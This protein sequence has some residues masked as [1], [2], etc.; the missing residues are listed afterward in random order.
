MDNSQTLESLAEELATAISLDKDIYNNLQDLMSQAVFSE[1]IQKS[2]QEL[3]LKAQKFLT[4]NESLNNQIAV[5]QKEYN[6]MKKSG[7]PA[8]TYASLRLKLVQTVQLRYTAAF[9]FDQQLTKFYGEVP[10]KALYVYEN[11]KGDLSTYELDLVGLI[12]A[13][14]YTGKILEGKA[15]SEAYKIIETDLK[16]KDKENE[17]H[18][19]QAQSAYRGITNRLGRF[20]EKANLST[21]QGGIVMWK[22]GRRWT[23]AQVLNYGDLKEAYAAAIMTKHLSDLDVLCGISPGS[24][25]YYSHELI[26]TFFT[27]YVYNVTNKAAVIEEDIVTDIAQ[28]AVKGAKSALPGISQY[29]KAAETITGNTN[30]MN[31]EEFKNALIAEFPEEVHRNKTYTSVKDLSVQE[32][33]ETQLQS[34]IKSSKYHFKKTI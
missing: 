29:I 11:S 7:D 14:D 17:R 31:R 22:L 15:K 24:P 18:I 33:S 8:I 5:L 25:P 26:S 4:T 2:W 1:D 21:N 3:Q 9:M 10:R 12:K 19:A 6:L 13:A 23:L 27:D 16:E 28:Y 20:Y 30:F 34:I 32:L